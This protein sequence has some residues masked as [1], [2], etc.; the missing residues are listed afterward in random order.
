[1]NEIEIRL[2]CESITK[3]SNLIDKGEEFICPECSKHNV[4]IAE[5]FKMPVNKE[6]IL[7]KEIELFLEKL[8]LNKNLNQ[9]VE[10]DFEEIIFQIDIQSE[11]LIQ[12]ID[13]YR[14]KSIEKIKLKQ[15]EIFSQLNQFKL[16]EI[17]ALSKIS[18]INEIEKMKNLFD[19]I[20][21]EEKIKQ[22]L[23]EKE[24]IENEIKDEIKK[25][26]FTQ[27]E[28]N[29]G[30][31]EL[32]GFLSINLVESGLDQFNKEFSNITQT[33][34]DPRQNNL[35]YNSCLT[36]LKLLDEKIDIFKEKRDECSFCLKINGIKKIIYHHTF[37]QIKSQKDSPNYNYQ[38]RMLN[39][40]LMSYLV[41]QNLCC[42]KFILWKLESFPIY[43]EL[44]INKKFSRWI[45]NG[46]IQI[47]NFDLKILCNLKTNLSII[48]KY[49]LCQSVLNLNPD[50]LVAF[51]DLVRF[52]VLDVY[53]GIYTDGD[54]FYL[55]DMSLLWTRNFAYKW[56]HLN[57]LN[58]AVLGINKNVDSRINE[59][60]DLIFEKFSLRPRYLILEKLD[61]II[62]KSH[63]ESISYFIGKDKLFN[64][65]YLKVYH[66]FLFDPIWLC[67]D[68]K[69]KV[70]N[71]K[72]VCSFSDF[73]KRAHIK[74]GE[75]KRENFFPGAFTYHIHSMP[76][77]YEI[78]ENSY[79]NFFEN[80]FRN[81]LV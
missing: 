18:F 46:Q 49:N 35:T 53:G 67:N 10:K 64:N 68:G 25:Y 69:I 81:K 1:M 62:A 2:V 60:Y 45:Q 26:K 9:S 57:E 50:K 47:R 77:K 7:R 74:Q 48:H 61:K 6:K 32:F 41:T 56:S 23:K 13:E 51:S 27:S 54:V 40:N 15:N 36:S 79:L 11:N 63:P 65:D 52:I 3:Y 31:E 75:F 73:T 22:K 43:L 42:T 76:N 14:M 33:K 34:C 38:Y 58:T 44:D 8:E 29:N 20:D 30:I 39:L 66:S 28:K 59:I 80:Y 72:L 21:F 37:W 78:H 71:E 12:K 5:T 70:L 55:K 19:K 17:G 16:S 24:K 4:N